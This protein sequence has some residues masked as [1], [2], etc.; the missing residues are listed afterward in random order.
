M[1]DGR[2]V[3]PMSG[4]KAHPSWHTTFLVALFIEQLAP[5]MYC[6]VQLLKNL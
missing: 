5:F 2:L 1:V 3:T 6:V 4:S